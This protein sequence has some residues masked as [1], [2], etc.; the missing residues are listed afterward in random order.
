MKMS[1]AAQRLIIYIGESDEWEGEPLYVALVKKFREMG[2]AGV[3]VVRGIMGYGANNR[4]HKAKL[5]TFSEDMP[6]RIEV[7]DKPEYIQQILPVLDEMVVDGL[8]AISNVEV[9]RYSQDPKKSARFA[10]G[11]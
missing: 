5:L 4:I 2:I 9:V 1:G 3:T 10:M 6:I 11:E 8:I 7:V